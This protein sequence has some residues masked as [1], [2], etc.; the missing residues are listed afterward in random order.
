MRKLMILCFC[1][2][3]VAFSA[4][5]GI[6]FAYSALETIEGD[7]QQIVIS[8][9]EGSDPK[10][11][12]S[13]IDQTLEPM[14]QD[15]MFRY[16][17]MS[18]DKPHY[19]YFKTNHTTDFIKIPAEAKVIRPK[20][21]ECHSTTHQS[22]CTEPLLK[23]PDNYQTL[24]IS[25]WYDAADFDLSSANF[26]V[27]ASYAQET[28]A[29]IQGLG[30]AVQLESGL[31]INMQMDRLLLLFVPAFMFVISAM[32]YSFSNGKQNVL[33]KME[34]Y[35]TLNILQEEARK[36][37]RWLGGCFL[38]I[39]CTT[40]IITALVFRTSFIQFYFFYLRY[41][42]ILLG[43]LIL[44]GLLAAIIVRLQNNAEFVK[45]RVPKKGM[46]FTTMFGK[47]V[48]LIFL[49]FSLSMAIR[50]II[51]V[52]SSIRTLDFIQEKV[53]N[54]VTIPIIESNVYLSD[55]EEN[56]LAFY[57]LTVDQHQGVLI[58]AGNY[59]HDT[60]TGSNLSID[61]GQ[62]FITINEN[63]LDLNPIYDPSGA[64]ITPG[65]FSDTQYNILI[66][67]TKQD[68]KEKY[69]EWIDL[70]YGLEVNFIGYDS[71]KSEIYSYNPGVGSDSLGRLDQPVI[72]MFDE[73]ME[74]AGL[75]IE[76]YCSQGDYF[77]KTYTDDP[78][79]E[80]LP[81]LE[82]AG[83]SSVS[84]RT[85]Y[86]SDNFNE[87]VAF[88]LSNLRLFLFQSAFFLQGL[89]SLIIFSVDL[90]C[91]INKQRIACSLIEGATIMGYMG[92]HF[93]AIGVTYLITTPLLGLSTKVTS[94]T[95]N[96]NLL[97]AAIALELI[98]TVVFANRIA[99]RNLYQ[100][101]KGAE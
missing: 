101:V 48:F 91:E 96:Y 65:R 64:V 62:D 19:K 82:Q 5:A 98:V 85:P 38:I 68:E 35:T 92:P 78:Y 11:F 22:D 8:N 32:F 53:A 80:L 56:Y 58:D 76:S 52:T 94:V 21:G 67:V 34:G 86:I 23:V 36:N 28:A 99:K 83:I 9:P 14:N 30:Y 43:I 69:V 79:Q 15:I 33:K 100:I 39:V 24:S 66:P 3:T 20:Q 87:M 93:I 61:F 31:N 81:I 55:P 2:L 97:I 89:V 47:I 70:W 6:N 41:L 12:L 71:S 54:Y 75:Y 51:G 13:Q 42:L 4:L 46:Y 63:Y 90:Y 72:L 49:L 18:G 74:Y 73:H 40:L 10:V 50:D 17:D 44:G 25:N 37:M 59:Y 57:R 27:E 7:K 1:V 84:I 45:G 95:V 16:I 60:F 77:V 26:F 29:A 88:Q